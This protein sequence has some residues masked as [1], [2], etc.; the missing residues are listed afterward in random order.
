MWR[1]VRLLE[2]EISEERVAS[3][4]RVEEISKRGE[5]LDGC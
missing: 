1:C 5:V 3:I 2:T 4:F